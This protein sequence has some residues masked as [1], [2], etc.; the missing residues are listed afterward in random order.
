[1]R[2][3]RPGTVGEEIRLGSRIPKMAHGLPKLAS[4]GKPERPRMEE[5]R[6]PEDSRREQNA[7]Q[8]DEEQL[9]VSTKAR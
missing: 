2:L 9:T 5:S 4:K 1:M 3:S 8:S 6:W 7:L